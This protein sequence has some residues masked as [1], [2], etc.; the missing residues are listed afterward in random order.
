MSCLTPVDTHS[1]SSS[2][3]LSQPFNF[4]EPNRAKHCVA[5]SCSPRQF[6]RQVMPFR[7][8][9]FVKHALL[10]S[11]HC[12]KKQ[13]GSA[14]M[15]PPCAANCSNPWLES[16]A[17]VALIGV[18]NRVAA[19]S[20][21]E[22]IWNADSTRDFLGSTDDMCLE[23]KLFNWRAAG[24]SGACSPQQATIMNDTWSTERMML[25][26]FGAMWW[27]HRVPVLLLPL[28]PVLL[29]TCFGRPEDHH[30]LSRK[31]PT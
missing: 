13:L 14:F 6:P 22:D 19:S 10:C 27:L 30:R 11:P 3:Q 16:A 12:S 18:K 26:I 23:F 7:Q 9:G 1:F 15:T 4:S 8:A 25:E 24:I 21:P 29:G 31:Y 17:L 20:R 5:H 28:V 2:V